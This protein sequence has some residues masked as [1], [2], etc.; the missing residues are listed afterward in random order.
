M[1]PIGIAVLAERFFTSRGPAT[2]ADFANWSG[3]PKYGARA[4][5]EDAASRLACEHIEGTDFWLVRDAIEGTGTYL[6]PAHDELC[7]GYK[8]RSHLFH[9]PRNPDLHLRRMLFASSSTDN[10]R[11]PGSAS[12]S[13]PES[14][15]RHDSKT[16]S[17]ESQWLGSDSRVPS[18]AGPHHFRPAARQSPP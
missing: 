11:A 10:W 4:G 13:K 8:I 5:L 7:I 17:T 16:P 12:C 2:L 9:R 6:L 18:T 15:L 1:A 14:R 3:L